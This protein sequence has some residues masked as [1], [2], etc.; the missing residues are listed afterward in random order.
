[1]RVGAE[2]E[3]QLPGSRSPRAQTRAAEAVSSTGRVRV[4][5]LI[6]SAS[7]G[8]TERHLLELLRGLDRSR[9]EPL[10]VCINPGGALREPL[11]ALDV[12]VLDLG[13]EQSYSLHG[14][15]RL[16]KLV[17]ELRRRRI[18]IFHAYHFHGNLYASLAAPLAGVPVLFVSERGKGYRGWH[19]RLAR[20]YYGWKSRRILVNCDAL[21]GYV[22]ESGPF[23]S[24]TLLIPNGVDRDKLQT[25][26]VARETRARLGIPESA[27]VIGSVGRLQP[28][29]GHRYLV[30]AFVLLASTCPDAYLLLVGG[31]PEEEGLSKHVEE[32]DLTGR[33]RFVGFQT[34]V[35][36]Y[37]EAIDYFVLPSL[38]EAHSMALL[39]ATAM[40]KPVVATAVGGNPETVQAG[41]T[42]LLVPPGSSEELRDALLRLL[43]EPG[44][45]ERLGRAALDFSAR[46]DLR[47]MVQRYALLY[48]E[49]AGS[50]SSGGEA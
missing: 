34:D 50:P 26:G 19:R 1:M 44:L 21:R 10:V 22:R 38:S 47:D 43:T 36:P 12:P 35:Q 32:A 7:I 27:K 3:L 9:F 33:V 39:E 11:G 48:S 2:V 20:R 16:L 13:I 30:D 24:K 6:G 18:Q 46:Y 15:F 17:G 37:M 41:V 45:A 29:K 42:G 49:F 14:L 40:G 5:Y 8:G 31:G 4:A 28:V 23:E 25:R